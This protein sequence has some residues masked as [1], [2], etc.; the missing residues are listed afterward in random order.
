M[1][2][3]PRALGLSGAI[4][5]GGLV[6]TLDPPMRSDSPISPNP[7][8]PPPP[9]G[10]FEKL[11]RE[12]SLACNCASSNEKRASSIYGAAHETAAPMSAVLRSGGAACRVWPMPNGYRRQREEKEEQRQRR[13]N[14]GAVTTSSYSGA[15]ACWR[16]GAG[17]A[18]TQLISHAYGVDKS[19]M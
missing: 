16:C 1:P 2:R 18:R 11:K 17:S 9:S 10:P 12:A 15:A 6:W 5:C 8:S 7:L 4:R 19:R 14:S 13:L 3:L